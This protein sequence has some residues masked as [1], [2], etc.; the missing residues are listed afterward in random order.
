MQKESQILNECMMANIIAIIMLAS[1]TTTY[2]LS[3]PSC[4]KTDIREE[5]KGKKKEKK[6]S[7]S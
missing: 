7:L 2:Q 1:C 6:K 3:P 4:S 5:K